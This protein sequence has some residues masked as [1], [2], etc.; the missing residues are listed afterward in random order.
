M[1][2]L[3]KSSFAARRVRTLL[4]TLAIAL[5]VSLVVAVTSGYASVESAALAYLNRYLGSADGE[6]S[7]PETLT[8]GTV[9]QR[10]MVELF[11]D[12]DIH[13]VTARLEVYSDL[14]DKNG[15]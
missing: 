6:I 1:L 3:I 15:K 5:S 9:P 10:L 4:T 11:K 13:R 2:S 12:P 8:D 7:R 14:L